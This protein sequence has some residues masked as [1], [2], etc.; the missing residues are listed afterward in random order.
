MP[1][2]ETI[3]VEHDRGVT[4]ITLNRPEQ[5]NAINLA[6]EKELYDAIFSVEADDDVRVIVITGV[7]SSFC[8]GVDL[9]GGAAFG[10]DADEEHDRALGVTS[11]T[12]WERVAVLADDDAHHRRHQRPRDRCGHDTGDAVRHPLRGRRRQAVVRVHAGAGSSPRRTRPGS[13]RD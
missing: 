4:T 2:Y 13:S 12:L 5:R 3:A 10:A 1:D 9:Q 6:M 11:D 8:S 7:G